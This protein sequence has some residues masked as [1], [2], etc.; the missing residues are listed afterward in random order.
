MP[1]KP[2]QGPSNLLWAIWS[3]GK[4]KQK[5][6]RLNLFSKI[7]QEFFDR[8]S[9]NFEDDCFNDDVMMIDLLQFELKNVEKICEYLLAQVFKLFVD[10][11][12]IRSGNQ[13]FLRKFEIIIKNH[14]S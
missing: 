13:A 2:P 12:Q 4:K 3:H 1:K 10:F 7:F 8:D 14:L 9:P 11:V 6:F 5:K